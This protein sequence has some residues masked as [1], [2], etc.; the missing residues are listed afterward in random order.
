MV[1]LV[2]K[3]SPL[4][5]F[6][7]ASLW[8]PEINVC[9]CEQRQRNRPDNVTSRMSRS[10]TFTG[11]ECLTHSTFKFHQLSSRSRDHCYLYFIADICA[12]VPHHGVFPEE[13]RMKIEPERLEAD[14]VLDVDRFWNLSSITF[15]LLPCSFF[16]IRVSLEIR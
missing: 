14:L 1:P 12:V 6:T 16:N 5:F 7:A 2:R 9:N 3:M 4:W 13:M 8:V 10:T 11:L 15:Q